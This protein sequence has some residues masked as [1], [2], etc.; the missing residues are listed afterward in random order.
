MTGL[1]S[2]DELW[3]LEADSVVAHLTISI[4]VGTMMSSSQQLQLATQR[5]SLGTSAH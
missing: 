2:P 4:H 3:A 1:T 5:F